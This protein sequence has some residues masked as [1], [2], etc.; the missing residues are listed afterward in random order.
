VL[1]QEED[2]VEPVSLAI[3]IALLGGLEARLVAGGVHRRGKGRGEKGIFEFSCK[4]CISRKR[5]F[6]GRVMT[7]R[8]REYA[9]HFIHGFL[10]QSHAPADCI[11]VLRQLSTVGSVA[12]LL[13]SKA[14]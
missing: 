11:S 5:L 3:H 6:V 4:N 1:E 2:K 14:S 12:L 13:S 10:N 8:R 7:G 9:K